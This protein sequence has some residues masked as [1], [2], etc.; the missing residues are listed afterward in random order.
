MRALH[1]AGIEVILDVV[2][3]H[4]CEGNHLGPTLSFRG[5]DNAV[6]YKLSPDNPR[7]YWD[8]TGTGNTLNVS[9]PR[10]LQMVMDSLRHWVEHYHVDGFR[11][12]LASTLARDPHDF[13]QRAAF[14]QACLQ[15]PVLSRVKL[16]AEPW[17]VG[18]GRLSG[19]RLPDPVERVERPVSRHD[20]RLLARRPRPAAE[21]DPGDDRLA[22]N[23]RAVRARALGVGQLRDRA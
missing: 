6:Y 12:D 7:F 23:L 1:D 13:S 20:A 16:I 15:D 19:R 5:I 21:A 11:F 14:L 10:V 8:S 18:A 9:H 2:Y 17:D 22:R 3:N 4:T